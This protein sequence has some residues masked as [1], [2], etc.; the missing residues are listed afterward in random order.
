LTT[1]EKLSNL[2]YTFKTK[3]PG[4]PEQA[5]VLKTDYEILFPGFMLVAF[6]G[7]F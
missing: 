5:G 1:F 7:I 2:I 4:L 3:N 6:Q